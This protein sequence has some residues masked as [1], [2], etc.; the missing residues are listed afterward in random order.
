VPVPAGR[1]DAAGAGGVGVTAGRWRS[2]LFAPAVRPDVVAKTPRTGPDAIVADLEDAVPP[3][4]KESARAQARDATAAVAAAHPGIAVLVRV[5]GVGTPWFDGDVAGAL[6]AGL[7]G[8]VVPKV[9]HPD[10]VV[11]ARRALAAAG[12][13]HL[14]VVAGLESAWGVARCEELA[15]LADVVYFGAED[16]TADVGGRR[17]VE[18]VEVLYAR[19]RVALAARLAGVPALDQV[20]TALDDADRFRRDAALGRDLGYAGKL[21]IHPAQVALSHAAFSPT[22]A[23]LDHARRVVA[24]SEDAAARGEAAV[25][26][27][28]EM[29]DE[30]IVRRAR[31][32]LAF[33]AGGDGPTG[34]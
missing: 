19:S 22:P 29:V 34:A 5:N 31:A 9:E 17:T 13:A 6:H 2:L 25:V 26:V 11:V 24:A 12:L 14:V 8:V 21:C 3:A 4:A 15:P 16:Y 10:H 23:E 28:G 1:A 7:A 18:G 32:L 20:V 33:D 30:P 27:D